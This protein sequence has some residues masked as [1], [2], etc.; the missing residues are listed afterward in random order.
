MYTLKIAWRNILRYRRRSLVTILTVVAGVCGIT[1]FGGYVQANYTGLRESVI[2]SQYGHLQIHKRGFVAH[3]A[4]NPDKF[5]LSKGEVDRIA[6]L[7][8]QSSDI[9]LFCR[10]TEFTAVLGSDVKSHA[11]LV[12]AVDVEEESLMN[13]ALTMIDGT[14]LSSDEPEGAILGEGL[15]RAVAAKVGDSFSLLATTTSGALNG[16]DIKVVGIFK[17]L[18][19]EFDDNA[20]M[21]ALPHATILMN[22][23]E[24]D[25]VVV[26][27][28]DT[29]RLKSFQTSLSREAAAAGLELEYQNWSD[30]AVFYHSVVDLYDGFFAFIAILVV[31]IVFFGISNTMAM[32]VMERTVE[33]GIQRALGTKRIAIVKQ[34]LVEGTLLGLIGTV[35]GIGLGILLA[36]FITSLEIMM[37]PPPGTS[38]EIPLIIELVAWVWGVSLVG[39][40]GVAMLAS[41][42]PANFAAKKPIVDALRFV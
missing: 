30:L 23:E 36:Q 28:K 19:K 39:V 10:R 3:H 18:A 29:E 27:L 22:T 13:S 40:W 5:R 38:R 15:A 25:S 33:I 24:V 9:E 37:P 34:F 20:M 8:K 35:L 11:A 16:I 42:I 4:A 32:A 41:V 6:T 26:L 12:R 21:I 7:L 31:V 17:S 2:R 1:L 14:E